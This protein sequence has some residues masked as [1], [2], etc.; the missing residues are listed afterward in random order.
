MATNKESHLR[1]AI[2][3]LS[4]RL[5]ATTTIIIIVYLKTGQIESALAIGAIEFVI[6]YLLY[7][8]HER[9][10]AQIPIG[11]VRGFLKKK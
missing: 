6:K 4:W 8:G 9:I 10:W 7:F 11:T 2:K 3:G 1:S 5:I